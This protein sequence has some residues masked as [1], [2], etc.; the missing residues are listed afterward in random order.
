MKPGASMPI[1]DRTPVA[2]MGN[3]HATLG[4]RQLSAMLGACLNAAFRR[5]TKEAW[6]GSEEQRSF[7]EFEGG[8]V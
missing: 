6:A 7:R 2:S 1:V 3:R 4:A 5:E 8:G